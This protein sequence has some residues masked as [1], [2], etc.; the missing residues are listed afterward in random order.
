MPWISRLPNL[1]D[2]WLFLAAVIAGAAL[3]IL[4]KLRGARIRI[5]ALAVAC[6]PF[7][8]AA[9]VWLAFFPPAFRFGWASLF[10]L[11][12]IV[13]GWGVWK[14]RWSNVMIALAGLALGVVALTSFFVRFD[15]TAPT[16]RGSWLG[17]N[18]RYASLPSPPVKDVSLTSGLELLVPI[19]SD[20]CWSVYPLCTPQ[21]DPSLRTV[22]DHWPSGFV[23]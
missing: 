13:A 5:R 3:L 15:S 7:V 10:G 21:P 2:P 23:P 22:D 9:S 20:Q 4:A 16:E 1:W 11:A 19:E 6:A 12:A 17:V 14:M 8:L 18:Y